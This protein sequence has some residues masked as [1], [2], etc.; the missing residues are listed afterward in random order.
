[1]LGRQVHQAGCWLRLATSATNQCRGMQA[2]LSYNHTHSGSSSTHTCSN[3]H[4]PADLPVGSLDDLT[5][6]V[7]RQEAKY[8]LWR[9]VSPSRQPVSPGHSAGQGVLWCAGSRIPGCCH[10]PPQQQRQPCSQPCMTAAVPWLTGCSARGGG[11]WPGRAVVCGAG[12]QAHP[13]LGA[14]VAPHVLAG[15]AE[16]GHSAQVAR[17][18]LVLQGLRGGQ[19]RG[20]L[21]GQQL[22]DQVLGPADRGRTFVPVCMNL[23]A[24]AG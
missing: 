9:V 22:A 7:R 14:Q 24:S 15:L 13:K 12:P 19:A 5:R 11:A 20:G 8:T 16:V 17:Q 18:P 2:P 21:D 1:M 6:L 3:G 4:S 23:F 10:V